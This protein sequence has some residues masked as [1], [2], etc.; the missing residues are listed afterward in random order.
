M[1]PAIELLTQETIEKKLVNCEKLLIE[2]RKS[3]KESLH[4]QRKA[5]K[6]LHSEIDK[7][8]GII[9]ELDK[10]SLTEDLKWTFASVFAKMWDNKDAS[11]SK[12]RAFL[13][14]YKVIKQGCS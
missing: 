8:K 13:Q 2:N 14:S 3:F 12:L 7:L 10:N 9:E 5:N 6:I 4:R 1:K 11:P